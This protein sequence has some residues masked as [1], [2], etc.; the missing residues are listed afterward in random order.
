MDLNLKG[1]SVVVTG[2][3]SGIGRACVD[4][5]AEEGARVAILDR[6]ASGARNVARELTARGIQAVAIPADV[7]DDDSLKSAMGQIVDSFGGIDVLACC[8]GVSGL[9]GR[10]IEQIDTAEWDQVMAVN[11]R[12]QWLP[13]KR[14]LPFLRKSGRSAIVIVASDSA[15]VA[16]PLH[17]PYCTSK[18]AVLMLTR[19]LSVDLE[20]DG[21]RVNC[22]CPS[23]VDTPMARQDLGLEKAGFTGVSY[24]VQDPIQIARY[25]VFLGSTMS[26][27]IN[28]QALVADFGYTARS[29]FPV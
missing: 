12:G 5:F 19:A 22:V 27:S 4:A 26:S 20:R 11:V 16:S 25:M 18:G 7:T 21:V 1:A 29:A 24:P 3:A 6:N 15:L 17:V 2:G 8:A 28:G 9:Y 10:S 14:A 23:V 13:V